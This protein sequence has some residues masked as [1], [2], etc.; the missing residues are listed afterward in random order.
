MGSKVARRMGRQTGR[1]D[2]TSDDVWI[3]G[4]IAHAPLMWWAHY[5]QAVF[6]GTRYDCHKR[7]S[8]RTRTPSITT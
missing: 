7:S 2:S 3:I 4:S 6:V 8:R 1:T 5:T